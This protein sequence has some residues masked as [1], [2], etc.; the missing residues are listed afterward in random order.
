[1]EPFISL[2]YSEYLVASHL[3]E[4]FKP[5]KGYSIYAPLSRQQKGVDL[6]LSATEN[7]KTKTV[8]IQVKASRTYI[9]KPP[10]RSTTIRYSFDTWFNR[11]AVPEEADIFILLGLYLSD[12]GYSV[13]EKQWNPMLMV[14]TKK[15]MKDF[16]AG[17]KT[18]S[19]SAEKMFGFSF[20]VPTEIFLTRGDENRNHKDYSEY[21]LANRINLISKRLGKG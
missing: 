18:K 9:P 16:M 14:F 15:E 2:P 8:S 3:A 13:N 6:L 19:G 11:F 12:S 10:K 21:L 4:L 7:G 5:S 17:I 20:N 1:M